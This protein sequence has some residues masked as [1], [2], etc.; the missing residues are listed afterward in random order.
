MGQAGLRSEMMLPPGGCSLKPNRPMS[1]HLQHWPELPQ[2]ASAEGGTPAHRV[3][4]RLVV[5]KMSSW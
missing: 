3:A 5:L 2:Q 4:S 1:I